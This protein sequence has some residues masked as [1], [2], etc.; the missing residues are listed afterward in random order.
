MA[1]QPKKAAKKSQGFQGVR[2][3]IIIIALAF[4]AGWAFYNFF[5]GD[6]ANF[7]NGDREGHPLNMLGTVYKGG[8]V[9]PIILGLL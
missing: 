4:I 8:W 1:N 5:L 2:H 9:V 7:A 3:A 6:P